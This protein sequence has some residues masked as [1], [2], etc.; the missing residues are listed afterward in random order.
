MTGT[1]LRNQ[2][3]AF[4]HGDL[5]AVLVALCSGMYPRATR[6]SVLAELARRGVPKPPPVLAGSEPLFDLDM[7]GA[8]MP[9][10]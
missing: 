1:E 6:D 9:G 3:R 4:S 7:T 8:V 2:V 10:V 5:V